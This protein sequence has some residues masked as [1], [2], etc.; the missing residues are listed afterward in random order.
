MYGVSET[1]NSRVPEIRPGRPEDGNRSRFSTAL[2]IAATVLSAAPGLSRAIYS[3]R[4]SKLLRATRSHSTRTTRPFFHHLLDFLFG[5]EVSRVGLGQAFL[6]FVNLPFIH[7]NIFL[8]R[9]G[10]DEGAAPVH[11]FRQTVELVLEFGIQAESENRRFRHGVYIVHQLYTSY[12]NK[13]STIVS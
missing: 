8:N 3:A 4:Q 6:D 10:G 2:R 13:T 9:L 11:R 7:G 1:T 5:G 12:I